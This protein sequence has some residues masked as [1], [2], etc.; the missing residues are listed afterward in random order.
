MCSVVVVAVTGYA[1]G[2]PAALF[3]KCGFD[4]K[5]PSNPSCAAL[6]SKAISFEVTASGCSCAFY[7]G[8][9]APRQFDVEKERRRYRRRGLSAEKADRK[10][11][12]LR[13]EFEL[14]PTKH[15]RDRYGFVDAIEELARGGAKVTL[16][17]HFFHAS[18]DEPFK[19]KGSTEMPLGH[20]LEQ[21]GGFPEDRLVSLIV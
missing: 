21:G 8:E 18:F 5:R 1:G 14:N 9:H 16:L 19:I 6:P 15:Q 2:D 11:E 13:L 7:S 12:A 20:F 4:T 10:V 3:H 17:A